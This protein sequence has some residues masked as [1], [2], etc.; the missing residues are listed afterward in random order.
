MHQ[1]LLSTLS[2]YKTILLVGGWTGGHIQPIVSLTKHIKKT[3]QKPS[4]LWIGGSGSGEE[5]IAN[6]EHIEF[7]SIPTLK[8]TSTKSF[9]VLLYPFLLIFGFWKARKILW[10]VSNKT[11]TP[12]CVFSKWW[13]GSVAI[14]IAAWSLWIPLY[15]HESDTIPGRS[16]LM[17]SRLATKIFLG[18]ENAKQYFNPDKC[19]VIWQ[20][21]DPIFEGEKW[22]KKWEIQWK[23]NKPHIFVIC[24]SQWS[25]TIFQSIIDQFSDSNGYEWIIALGKLNAN[26]QS[27]FSSIVACQVLTWISQENIAEIIQDTDIAITRGSATTLAE[28]T[29]SPQKI[30]LIIVPLPFSADNHQYY[31][32]REYEKDGHILLEQ[33]DIK[34]LKN[35]ILSTLNNQW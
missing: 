16:N 21:L 9:K 31:N 28:L 13:P 2:K 26:M 8:L 35:T 3:D 20:I 7:N 1:S 18:F 32:A 34:N 33:K 19:E 14:G 23:T 25:Q 11:D 24:G 6:E 22:R 12:L 10:W 30:Q 4:F 15:I 17:L 29:T 5:K 27:A